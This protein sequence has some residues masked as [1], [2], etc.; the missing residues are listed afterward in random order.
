MSIGFDTAGLVNVPD[1]VPD[2]KFTQVESADVRDWQT[3]GALRRP[4]AS[5]GCGWGNTL[6]S[7]QEG[8]TG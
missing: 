2:N 5:P 3:A 6:E 8:S 1:Y 7:G 4:P